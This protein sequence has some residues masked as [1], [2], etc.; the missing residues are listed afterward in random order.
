MLQL[1]SNFTNPI[2]SFSLK[3]N[4]IA[5]LI[6]FVLFVSGLLSSIFYSV[7]I[8][9]RV[10]QGYEPNL[11]S[12][13]F[14]TLSALGTVWGLMAYYEFSNSSKRVLESC[15]LARQLD[16]LIGKYQYKTYNPELRDFEDGYAPLGPIDFWDKE[17]YAPTW[18]DKAKYWHILLGLQAADKEVVLQV[19]S[20]KEL[21][22]NGAQNIATT[23]REKVVNEHS[24]KFRRYR[25]RVRIPQWVVLSTDNAKS[26]NEDLRPDDFHSILRNYNKALLPAVNEIIEREKPR[27]KYPWLANG[28]LI[29]LNKSLPLRLIYNQIIKMLPNFGRSIVDDTNEGLVDVD[30]D[31]LCTA[32]Y[33]IATMKGINTQR[34]DFIKLL[35]AFLKTAYSNIGLGEG[36]TSYHNF[37]H[38]LEVS[39][40]ALQ[41]VPNEIYG[42]R[43]F[44]REIEIL[45]VAALLHD[46]DPMQERIGS[47]VND[48]GQKKAKG[49]MGPTVYRTIQE[50]RRL[51]IHDAYFTMSL[52]DFEAF[53]KRKLDDTS[54]TDVQSNLNYTQPNESLI[55][56]A[57]IWRT[58]FPYHKRVLSQ[59]M[60]SRLLSELKDR[61]QNIEKISLLSEILWLSDLSVTYMGSDPVSAWTRV[62]SLYDEL[63]LPRLEAVSRTDTFFSDFAETKL[64]LELINSKSFPSIFKN[65]W[66]LVYQFFHE[67]NPSTALVRTINNARKSY[68]KINMEIGL[69]KGDNLY[70]IAEKNWSEYFI[71]I[72][73]NQQ[74]VLIAKSKF[75]MLEPQNAAAFW[76]DTM[77][78]GS[79]LVNQSIDNFLMRMPRKHIRLRD[80]EI[81]SLRSLIDILPLK[82]VDTGS[83][84]VMTDIEQDSPL[85]IDLTRLVLSAG[86]SEITTNSIKNYFDSEKDRDDDFTDEVNVLIFRK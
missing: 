11:Y 24:S 17:T 62:T 66:N 56:E 29:Y 48:N 33:H 53:L 75:M 83:L 71:G 15:N 61:G 63:Y 20:D 26:I 38:S 50:L 16:P 39:Y 77:K 46:Y 1:V 28:F 3:Y 64:F 8:V 31:K 68:L 47:L 84:Q 25:Y 73:K 45:V 44:P 67:G 13:L 70:N 52:G 27:I 4:K 41:M 32:I 57:Y 35:V 12:D 72:S 82:L 22:L 43:F 65:R 34:M 30:E 59:E 55:V 10:L 60:F 79:A 85:F 54:D 81:S 18:L 14:V 69:L 51:K 5:K 21:S 40:M 19:V 23:Q 2:R 6:F 42:Y 36:S 58:D 86:F 37:H 7:D 9:F 49:P 76:G 78:L 80:S 74:E